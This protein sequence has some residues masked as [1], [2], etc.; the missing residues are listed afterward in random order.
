MWYVPESYNFTLLNKDYQY[1]NQ[2]G[3]HSSNDIMLDLRE[4]NPTTNT[5]S[6]AGRP[7]WIPTGGDE[8]NSPTHGFIRGM[9]HMLE[10][11]TGNL[12]TRPFNHTEANDAITVP[13]P[14][15]YPVRCAIDGQGVR[16]ISGILNNARADGGPHANPVVR[17]GQRPTDQGAATPAV[18]YWFVDASENTAQNVNPGEDLKWCCFQYYESQGNTG[19]F[20]HLATAGANLSGQNHVTG[21]VSRF[22]S[23]VDGTHAVDGDLGYEVHMVECVIERDV[24]STRTQLPNTSYMDIPTAAQGAQDGF[25]TLARLGAAFTSTPIIST[26]S[27]RANSLKFQTNILYEFGQQSYV[28]ERDGKMI[29]SESYPGINVDKNL[30]PGRQFVGDQQL[31]VIKKLRGKF[32]ADEYDRQ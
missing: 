2:N 19:R 27:D 21:D 28:V 20:L 18:E 23:V 29:S 22:R 4:W 10:E 26:S 3:V 25:G 6:D 31:P 24:F 30:A 13:G 8:V 5:W 12:V 32:G 11:T 7:R 9:I 17:G 14:R 1:I 16:S 15:A